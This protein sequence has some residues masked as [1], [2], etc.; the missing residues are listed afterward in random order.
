MYNF[1]TYDKQIEYLIN[2][3]GKIF[4]QWVDALGL[5]KYAGYE[6]GQK[7][8]FKHGIDSTYPGCLT[9]IRG[10][11]RAKVSIKGIIDED[12]TMAIKKDTRLPSCGSKIEIKHLPVFKEWQEK[13][14]ALQMN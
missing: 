11:F 3:P 1:T 8:A 2:N 5:F 9:Q 10:N 13:V 6:S 4:D 7:P 14:D 12:I